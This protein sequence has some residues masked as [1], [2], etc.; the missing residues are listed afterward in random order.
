MSAFAIKPLQRGHGAV[1]AA[2]DCRTRAG[3]RRRASRRAVFMDTFVDPYVVPLCGRC[4]IEWQQT[5]ST[6]FGRRG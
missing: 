5:W 1:C 4:A 6:T 2:D 3:G